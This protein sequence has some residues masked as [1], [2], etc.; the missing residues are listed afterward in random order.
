MISRSSS[1]VEASARFAAMTAAAGAR[2][3]D[4]GDG[5][6]S[7]LVARLG[8]CQLAV[9]RHQRDLLRLQVILRSE[10]VEIPLRHPLH[11]VLLRG[12][13]VC[14]GLRHLRVRAL[15]RLPVFPAKQILLQ[16][17]GVLMNGG[18]DLA[19]ERE[20]FGH[21]RGSS[22]RGAGRAGRCGG[23]AGGQ[24]KRLGLAYRTRIAFARNMAITGQLGQ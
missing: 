18:V 22:R 9:D 16:V 3:L 17:D 1:C 23:G 20:G 11:E 4:V 24:G 7:D 6:Q 21:R 14:L 15:Q 13:V 10:N 12:L 8:L 2:L 5:D 19:A